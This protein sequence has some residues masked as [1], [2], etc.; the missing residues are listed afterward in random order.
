MSTSAGFPVRGQA[1]GSVCS[2]VAMQCWSC[3]SQ[4]PVGV[5][6]RARKNVFVLEMNMRVVLL[7]MHGLD[8]NSVDPLFLSEC[9]CVCVRHSIV[10]A[11][12]GLF[13]SEGEVVRSVSSRTILFLKVAL[14]RPAGA[15]R[16]ALSSGSP[17]DLRGPSCNCPGAFDYHE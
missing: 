14:A 10:H 4:S 5:G 15:V 16:R 2:D 7:L 9:V 1:R 3:D 6:G 17:C 8:E 12:S 13:A 11:L